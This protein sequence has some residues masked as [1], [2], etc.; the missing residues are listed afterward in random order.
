MKRTSFLMMGS[1]L[2][3]SGVARSV[4]QSMPDALLRWAHLLVEEVPADRNRYGSHPTY[5][6]WNDAGTGS[7]ARNRSVCSSFVNHLLEHSFGYSASDIDA[8]FGKR[9]PQAVQ[10]HDTIAAGHGFTLVNRIVDI[11][12]GDIIAVAYPPGSKPTGHVMIAATRAAAHT[13]S[14]PVESGTQQYEIGVIDSA[15]SGHGP[16]DSRLRA[17]GTWTTGVG[18]GTLR[19]Y[20]REDGT[21][22]GYCWSTSSHSAFRPADVRHPVVGRLDSALVPKPSGAAGASTT[23]DDSGDNSDDGPVSDPD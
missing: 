18:R 6:E 4:E 5:V 23:G 14:R 11:R 1:L 8:W 15:N 12:P 9:V 21:I 20:G 13:A 17:D 3:F 16:A 22:A 2:P 10:Y 19:L 7:G